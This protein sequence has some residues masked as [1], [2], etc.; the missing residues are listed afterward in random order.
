VNVA[1]LL[2]RTEA[3]VCACVPSVPVDETPGVVLGTILGVAA[4]RFGRDKVTIFSSPGIAGLGSWLE[5]LIAESTGKE[6]NGLIPVD[7]EG[8]RDPDVYGADRLFVSLRLRS[9]DPDPTRDQLL[10][11]LERAGHPVVRVTLEDP[12]DL[13][14]E[15]FRWEMATAVAGSILG[16]H[17]FDQPDVEASKTETRKLTAAYEERGRLPAET[18]IFEGDGIRLFTDEANVAA[19]ARTVQVL[20]RCRATWRRT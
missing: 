9:D 7:R 8:R 5:Q 1:E 2:D 10:A 6:G 15:F 12:Y 16:I 3:M 18:P 19:L 11:A 13:G 20:R 14:Q 17:P 4:K